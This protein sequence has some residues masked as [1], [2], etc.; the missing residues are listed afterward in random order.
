M[1]SLFE[2]E[3]PSFRVSVITEVD[4]ELLANLLRDAADYPSGAK[5]LGG[6]LDVCR[7]DVRW[8]SVGVCDERGIEA[9]VVERI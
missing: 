1:E 4:V 3:A 2:L 5:L 9:V 6:L 7:M 8:E